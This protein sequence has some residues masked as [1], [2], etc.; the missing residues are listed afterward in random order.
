MLRRLNVLI[1]FSLETHKLIDHNFC[2]HGRIFFSWD[3]FRVNRQVVWKFQNSLQIR[4]Q[5]VAEG[6]S[7]H[8]QRNAHAHARLSATSFNSLADVGRDSNSFSTP[9]GF[10]HT[11]FSCALRLTHKNVILI[12]SQTS[13]SVCVV[14]KLSRSIWELRILTRAIP[15]NF[16]VHPSQNYIVEV[17]SRY[18]Y[19]SR[20]IF[21]FRLLNKKEGI[22]IQS[23]TVV[24]H[25]ELV[26]EFE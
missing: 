6:Y 8:Y 21:V 15:A 10:E 2:S 25:Y 13:P 19:L 11:R 26:V 17:T 1:R 22:F 3:N 9:P 16:L 18:E 23:C 12:R 20:S 7:S 4:Q 24:S 5:N 14:E